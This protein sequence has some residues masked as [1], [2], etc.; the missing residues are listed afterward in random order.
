MRKDLTQAN[1]SANTPDSSTGKSDFINIFGNINR[2]SSNQ[3]ETNNAE[4]EDRELYEDEKDILKQFEANDKELEN[5]A[6]VIVGALDEL[7]GK[8][9]NI[10]DGVKRQGDLLKNTRKAAEENEAKL[11]QQNNQLKM[12]LEKH[13]NGKQ[14]CL[15]LTLLLIFIGL[16]GI[17]LKLLKLKGYL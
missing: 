8:A 6:A 5:I 11:R 17:L 7:K 10:E 1:N 4:E 15:D 9:Q 16:L 3:D 2:G 13:K 12:A 14:I